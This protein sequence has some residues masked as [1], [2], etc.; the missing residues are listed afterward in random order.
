MSILGFLQIDFNYIYPHINTIL[1]S[2]Q[3]V[4]RSITPVSSMRNN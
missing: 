4:L 3:G 2:L 1:D